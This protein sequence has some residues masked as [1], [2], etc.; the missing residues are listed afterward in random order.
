MSVPDAQK[1]AHRLF[2][3]LCGSDKE[4]KCEG[5]VPDQID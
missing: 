1:I 5:Q 4:G 2:D 3:L